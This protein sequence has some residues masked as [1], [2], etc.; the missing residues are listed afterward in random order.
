MNGDRGRAAPGRVAAALPWLAAA[1]ALLGGT[2][3]VMLEANQTPF[4]NPSGTVRTFSTNG[5]IDTTT[6]FFQDLGTNGRTCSTCHVEANG[7]S[8]TPTRVQ[9]RFN[10]SNGTDPLFRTNDGSNSPNAN[11]STTAA[12]RT[13]FSMLLN[14]A[15]IRIGIRIPAGAEFSLTAV[16]DPYR[17]ASAAQLSLFRRPPP[18]TNL[19]FLS[20]VMWDG[21][22]T[23]QPMTVT[24]TDAQNTQALQANLSSQATGATL[25]HAQAT[26]APTAAQLQQIVAFETALST[27]QGADNAAG[28]LNDQ[29]ALGGP[30]N[31]SNQDFHIG[32]NDLQGQDP[33][34]SPFNPQAMTLYDAWASLSGSDATTA[35]RLSVARGQALFNSRRITITAVGGLNRITGDPFTGPVQ[36]TCTTCHNT[37]NV[38]NHSVSMFLNTGTTGDHPEALARTSDL[39]LYTLQCNS[40]PLAGRTVKTTDPGRAL[41]TGKCADIGKTKGPVLRGLAARPPYFHN[42]SAGTLRDVVNFYDQR[43]AIGLS[44]QEKKDLTAFLQAL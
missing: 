20:D 2:A 24:K 22:E 3:A 29:G 31:L 41:I 17:F 23:G 10:A 32:T 26:T 4:P 21:R 14:K 7:W 6:P 25:Q 13:A 42:G 12:R 28:N 35:A 44:E 27:A 16:N 36:G 9:N 40:G 38:G 15:V 5:T 39:P 8:L 19:R 43:F 34:G 33:D 1:L 11:V 18:A 37:P 30:Q